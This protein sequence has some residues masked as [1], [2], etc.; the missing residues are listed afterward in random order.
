MKPR[1]PAA[2][3]AAIALAGCASLGTVAPQSLDES[4]FMA[5]AQVTGLD[6]T[7]AQ[8]LSAG[9]ITAQDGQFIMNLTDQI[10]AAINAAKAAEGAGNTSTAQGQLAVAAQLMSQLAVYLQGKGVGK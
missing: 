8:A 7:A 3:A 6:T 1:T 9:L 5:E 4:I 10:M 2:V